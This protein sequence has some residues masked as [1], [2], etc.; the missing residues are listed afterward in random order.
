MVLSI[1]IVVVLTLSITKLI[2]KKHK[3]DG[4]HEVDLWLETGQQLCIS[5]QS[6]YDHL[7][8]SWD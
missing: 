1:H 5:F 8:S 2:T 7:T 4:I 6:I 3:S